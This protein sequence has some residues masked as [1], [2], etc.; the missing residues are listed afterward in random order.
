[1]ANFYRILLLA[2]VVVT[3]AHAG[4]F[5]FFAG[6]DAP[7]TPFDL[8]SLAWLYQEAVKE[9]P[10]FIIHIGDIKNGRSP[11][12]EHVY[13][14]VQKLF[15][16]QPV[17]VLYTPGDNEWTDCW[18]P[19]AGGF[20][21]EERLNK[22]R[23]LFFSDPAV[24]KLDRLK[25][26][27]QENYPEHYRFMM[28]DVMFVALNIVGSY[29]NRY[30]RRANSMKEFGARSKAGGLFLRKSFNEAKKMKAKGL[31]VMFHANPQFE[32]KTPHPGYKYL[33]EGLAAGM[34][35][36]DRP[37]LAIHGDYHKYL[38]D[39]PLKDPETGKSIPKLTRL[40]VPGYPFTQVVEVRVDTDGDNLFDIKMFSS[41]GL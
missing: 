6:G 25:A 10:R 33:L 22:L 24:L 8:P 4:K 28:D 11:C 12:S 1:M 29:N 21:P 32:R 5:L 15:L 16:K 37:V 23:Q 34:K 41:S 26:H 18:R 38:V 14:Q 13:L 7:Y 9:K 27:H 17:P 35:G 39:Q 40:Q 3:P 20:D 19:T 30:P 31:V 2:F 36:W